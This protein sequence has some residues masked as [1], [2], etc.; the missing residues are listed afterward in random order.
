MN[1]TEIAKKSLTL[2]ADAKTYVAL[3]TVRLFVL[4]FVDEG[5]IDKDTVEDI[6]KS[7]RCFLQLWSIPNHL[8]DWYS[9]QNLR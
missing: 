9:K 2:L 8:W 6:E 3:P 7:T 1:N 5:K 4:W